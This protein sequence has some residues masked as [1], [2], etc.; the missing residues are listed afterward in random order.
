MRGVPSRDGPPPSSLSSSRARLHALLGDRRRAVATLALSSMVSGFAEAGILVLLAQIAAT[1]VNKHKQVT[2]SA[3]LLHPHAG[4][5][6]L[7]LIAAALGVV[8]LALQAPLSILP[9]RIAADVQARLRKDLFHAFTRASWAVQSS[10]REG[11]MQETMTSQVIQA[12]FG[13][14]Q[15]TTLLST[16]I[17][18]LVLMISALALN[19]VAA[20]VILAAA[21]ALFA[22][23]RPLNRLGA[24]RSRQ[25]SA[26]QMQYAGGIGES[27]RV[28]EETQVFGVA[29]AQRR[30]MD[31]LIDAARG[32]FYRT[33]LIGR[34]VPNL[35][36]SLMYLLIVGGLAALYLVSSRDV[37]SLAGVILLLVRAGSNGQQIQGAYQSLRQSLPFIE[38]LQE[39]SQRYGESTP[40]TGRRPLASVERLAFEDVSFSYR[41]GQPV[42]RHIGFEVAGGEAV[43][44]IGPS[45]AGKSTLVQ[46]LLQLRAP[47]GGRYLANGFAAWEIAREDWHRRVAYVPQEPRLV[48]A[49][50][51]DNIRYFRA[52]IDD[53][54]VVRA[55]RLARIHDDIMS[56]PDGYATIVGPRADAVSGGQQQRICLAR[57]LAAQPQVLVLDEPTSALDPQSE[58]LIQQSLLTLKGELTLFIIAHRMSTLYVCDRVMVIDA[59]RLVAFDTIERLQRENAYYRSATGLATGASAGASPGPEVGDVTHLE[60]AGEAVVE[61]AQAVLDAARATVDGVPRARGRLPDFF[62]AGQPKSGT[63]ALYEMLRRHPQIYLPERKEPRFFVSEMSLRDPPRPGGTPQTLEEYLSWFDAAG[64]EQRIGDASPWCLWSPTAAQRIV[65]V[66]PEARI[67]AILRDPASLL[68]S[69]HLEF[70]QLYVEVETDL[71]TAL[72]LEDDRRQGRNV[73]RNTYWPNALMYSDHVRTVEQLQRFHAVFPPEQVLVLIYD[74]FRADNEAT[75]RRVLRFLGVNDSLPVQVMDANPSVAVRSR[76]LHE[77]THAVQVGHG[78][79]SRAVKSSVKAITPRE[80]RRGALR[81]VQNRLVFTDAPPPEEGVM[82]ELRS[83]F[84]GEVVA[85]SEYL[86]RDLVSLWGYD[87]VDAGA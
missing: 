7:F 20:G 58:M 45:G 21:L 24:S 40:V 9:A 85:L 77:L 50:V 69:L 79:V 23:L 47:V 22:A 44:I 35:Y 39:A 32:L 81:E 2:L 30:R 1:L 48:H 83:R 71:R 53:R 8:R 36:Q 46:I 57:A 73:P 25:L 60:E 84:K 18:F 64:P 70:V 34:L 87:R 5:G 4:V 43:G 68:R 66:C 61:A 13:A 55:A 75:V 41:A 65:E 28:A 54:A 19:V 17:T 37:A 6:A 15:A 86:E 49:S 11:H 63:T 62:I 38:R 10:D 67:V 52:G 80:L 3:G 31:G 56:W 42:L 59:G 82:D 74:D 78:P 33:Q 29:E 51:A 27:V 16:L 26:A 14:L 12:T 72:A 76:R